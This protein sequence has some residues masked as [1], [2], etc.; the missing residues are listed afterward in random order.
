VSPD[1][2]ASRDN[3]ARDLAVIQPF[4]GQ[5]LTDEEVR[6]RRRERARERREMEDLDFQ[7]KMAQEIRRL[8]PGCSAKR[9]Q[10]I[11]RHTGTRGSGR[12]GRTAAG[13]AL[14]EDAITGAVIASVRHRDTAYDA[15][16]MEGHSREEARARVW[17]DV[18]E[19]LEAWRAGRPSI[20]L[21]YPLDGGGQR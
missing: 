20:S 18:E 11:A 10:E 7:A 6:Q 17:D 16:L 13:R 21:G 12:V 1:D 19:L 14:D 3:Q 4:K 2:G 9:A 8:F 15:L 5:R